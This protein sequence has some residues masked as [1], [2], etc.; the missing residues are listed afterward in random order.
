MWAFVDNNDWLTTNISVTLRFNFTASL[1]LECDDGSTV[2][3]M[4]AFRC[5]GYEDCEGDASD[6]KEDSCTND[7]KGYS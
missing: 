4:L 1:V 7:G 5:D 2:D 3:D 6:E